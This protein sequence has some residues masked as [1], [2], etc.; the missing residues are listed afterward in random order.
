MAD[1]VSGVLVERTG[2]E[3][4]EE[5]GE[6]EEETVT[7]GGSWTLIAWREAGEADVVVVS[8]VR[9]CRGEVGGCRCTT[10]VELTFSFASV[11]GSRPFRAPP[12][13]PCWCAD[14]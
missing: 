2:E 1:R 3:T 4:R 6:R 13:P 14:V 9:E 5:T 10:G 8:L 7:A 12:L 11:S